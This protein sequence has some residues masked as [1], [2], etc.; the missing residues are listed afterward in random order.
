MKAIRIVS[1]VTL[2]LAYT[3]VSFSQTKT[4]T[5]QVSGNC[6]MCKSK[7]E[8][9]AKD[10]GAQKASWNKDSKKLT[11]TYSSSSTNTAKIQ[12]M[13]AEAG[14]DNAGF[15]ATNEAYNKLHSCCQYDR[16]GATVK[17]NGCSDD[18]SMKDGKDKD[19]CKDAKSGKGADCCKKAKASN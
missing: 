10:A 6:G 12:K 18:C 15:K 16:N 5:F 13:I 11:V 3:A 8:K 14:Y 9:A 17:E 2:C 7:I 1:F 4:E 19:C